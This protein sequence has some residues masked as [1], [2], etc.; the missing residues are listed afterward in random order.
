VVELVGELQ[1]GIPLSLVD[2]GDRRLALITKA[3][4]FGGE[5]LFL[6]IPGLLR[7]R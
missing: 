6:D 3:G 7:R 4:G 5:T 2:Y 1:P